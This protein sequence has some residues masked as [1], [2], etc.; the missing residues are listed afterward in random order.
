LLV[1]Q[2]KNISNY[3]KIYRNF[4]IDKTLNKRLKKYKMINDY[5]MYKDVNNYK[6][7]NDKIL[8]DYDIAMIELKNFL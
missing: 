4:L 3:K 2:I 5:Q 7:E 1:E 6:I 8:N